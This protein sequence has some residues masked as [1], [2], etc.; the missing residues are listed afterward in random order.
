MVI[1][2]LADVPEV[3]PTLAAAFQADH[4]AH[5]EDRS[6]E[7][8]VTRLR[9]LAQ[10]DDLPLALVMLEG[11]EVCGTVALNRDSISTRRE[12]GPWV[13]GFYV[14]P[15]FRRQHR[16]SQLVRAAEAEAQR[17]GFRTIYTGTST[18]YSLFQRLGWVAVERLEY[19]GERLVICRKDLAPAA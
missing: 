17:L 8:S 4:F 10:R 16:G 3:I 5:P 11:A 1:R 19:C 7:D 6:L 14:L 15:K 18:A 9:R 13:A 12:L 2:Y